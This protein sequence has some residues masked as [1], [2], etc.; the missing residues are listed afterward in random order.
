[1][2]RLPP[3]V[4]TEYKH[5]AVVCPDALKLVAPQWRKVVFLVAVDAD[6]QKVLGMNEQYYKNLA[7]NTRLALKAIQDRNSIIAYYKACIRSA[8]EAVDND[9]D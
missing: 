3:L 8:N 9:E 5:I 4:T 1:M 7:V 6:G 2:K